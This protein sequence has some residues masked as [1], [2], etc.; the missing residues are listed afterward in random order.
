MSKYNV[1]NDYLTGFHITLNEIR[2]CHDT[3]TGIFDRTQNFQ[4]AVF[5]SE[6][7]CRRHGFL[8]FFSI[9]VQRLH[10]IGFDFDF[11]LVGFKLIRS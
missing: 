11:F 6:A 1:N 4:K 8:T 10:E 5:S 9:A 7:R 3:D 2:I